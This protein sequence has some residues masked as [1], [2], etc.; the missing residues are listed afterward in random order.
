VFWEFDGNHRNERGKV[1][2]NE[3]KKEMGGNNPDLSPGSFMVTLMQQ[4]V[5][6]ANVIHQLQSIMQQQPSGFVFSQNNDSKF[7]SKPLKLT[8]LCQNK[9]KWI[10]DSEAMD[11]MTYDVNKL[12]NI[13]PLNNSQ[14]MTITNVILNT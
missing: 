13:T 5:Q 8:Q 2:G 10:V 3:Q 14:H 1:I 9:N 12:R 7:S 4:N 6:L 11:H